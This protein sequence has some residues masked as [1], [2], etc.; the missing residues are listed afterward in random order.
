MNIFLFDTN[1]FWCS[2]MKRVAENSIE[3]EKEDESS[4]ATSSSAASMESEYEM[5]EEESGY[6][7]NNTRKKTRNISTLPTKDEQL[8][9]NNTSTLLR[10]NLL[11]LQVEEVLEE[12]SCEP[13]LNKK[14][15]KNCIQECIN[16]LESIEHSKLNGKEMSSSWLKKEGLEGF[17]VIYRDLKRVTSIPPGSDSIKFVPPSS[18]QI[19]GSSLLNTGTAPFVN[20]DISVGMPESI[21]SAND[22][23][24]QVYFKKRT[25]YLAGICAVLLSATSFVN[26][27]TCSV[28]LL[29]GDIRESQ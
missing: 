9:L 13:L 6:I 25:L 18:V 15:I 17:D 19:V 14:K 26:E 22:I 21:F 4:D 8:Q 5:M 23:L 28:A 10:A 24:N 20:I 12:V 3:I 7:N 2:R 16:T 29:K 1:T 27:K 11:K